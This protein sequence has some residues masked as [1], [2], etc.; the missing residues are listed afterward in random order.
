[1]QQWRGTVWRIEWPG[2]LQQITFFLRQQIKSLSSVNWH[3]L[4]S[5]YSNLIVGHWC[6]FCHFN[7]I[8]S[9]SLKILKVP[10]KDSLSLRCCFWYHFY[11]MIFIYGAVSCLSSFYSKRGNRFWICIIC[12]CSSVWM[13]GDGYQPVFAATGSC[14]CKQSVLLWHW[15]LASSFTASLPASW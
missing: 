10:R 7:V 13:I 4:S 14:I 8:A 1:M 3:P 9:F 12:R 6:E 15:T 11:M 2:Q 5:L